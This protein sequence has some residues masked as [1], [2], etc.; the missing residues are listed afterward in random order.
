MSPQSNTSAELLSTSEASVV[1][2]DST[3]TWTFIFPAG[4]PGIACAA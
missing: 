3:F 1:V 4:I 2:F